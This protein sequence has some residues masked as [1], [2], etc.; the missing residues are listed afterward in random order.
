MRRPNFFIAGAPKAG[1]T[2]LSAYLSQHPNAFLA[3]PKEPHYF[4]EDLPAI[5]QVADALRIFPREQ[6]HCCIFDELR[7]DPQATYERVRRFLGIA[8]A[9][10]PEFAVVNP[11]RRYRSRRLAALVERQPPVFSKRVRRLKLRRLNTKVAPR[12]PMDARL[13]RRLVHCFRE[14]VR[15]LEE[16]LDRDLA[17]WRKAA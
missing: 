11:N 12:P 3:K 4:A 16:V 13:R 2:A 17:P 6:V 8:K 1:T 9:S 5:R 10:P 7:S 14:D 15:L